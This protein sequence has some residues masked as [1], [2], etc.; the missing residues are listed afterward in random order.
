MATSPAPTLT[1][2]LSLDLA[3]SRRERIRIAGTILSIT[4]GYRSRYR[5]AL[6]TTDIG[7]ARVQFTTSLNSTLANQPRA[8]Q[9][10]VDVTLTGLVDVAN[11]VYMA[12]RVRLIEARQGPEAQGPI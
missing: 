10:V 2:T 1:D 6:I 4:D 12:E 9:I 3:A 8:S 5:Q 7:I 11:G